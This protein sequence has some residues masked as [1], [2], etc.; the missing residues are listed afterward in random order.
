M[1]RTYKSDMVFCQ[2]IVV[3]EEKLNSVVSPFGYKTKV[4]KMEYGG[5]GL[6]T[7]FKEEYENV[8]K[9]L[10]VG[11]GRIQEIHFK[12]EVFMNIYGP[13]G[14]SLKMER[15]EFFGETLYNLMRGEMRPIVGGDWNCV[16]NEKDVDKF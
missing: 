1:I 7:I 8:I 6:A 15:R 16:C 12:N 14:T 4:G 11:S 9:V 3:N 2:E 10:N 5:L 13:S